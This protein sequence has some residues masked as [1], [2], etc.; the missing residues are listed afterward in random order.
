MY[1]EKIS[2]LVKNERT[3]ESKEE[4]KKESCSEIDEDQDERDKALF[5]QLIQSFEDSLEH[6]AKQ[7]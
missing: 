1:K 7:N 4:D 6:L 2:T 3:S 5:D